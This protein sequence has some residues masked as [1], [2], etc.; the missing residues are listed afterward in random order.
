MNVH[1]SDCALHN[2]PAIEEAPCDCG[3]EAF[4]RHILTVCALHMAGHFCETMDTEG[5]QDV[6]NMIHAAKKDLKELAASFVDDEAHADRILKTMQEEPAFSEFLGKTMDCELL[7]SMF[8][9]IYHIA[10]SPVIT[11]SDL[12]NLTEALNDLGDET[13]PILH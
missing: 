5:A 4:M 7:E 9:I 11:L 6:F 10:K 1:K 3:A 13:P 2:T 8:G 12:P